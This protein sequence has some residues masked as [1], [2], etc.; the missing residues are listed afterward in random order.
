[1]HSRQ[2]PRALFG[3]LLLL[4]IPLSLAQAITEAARAKAMDAIE[5]KYRALV[6]RPLPERQKQTLAFMKT[7]PVVG[8]AKI[9]ED[10]NICL[11]FKD[12]VPYQ[13]VTNARYD[14]PP[15]KAQLLLLRPDLWAPFARDADPT[16]ER[17][18]YAAPESLLAP[19]TLQ[20][21]KPND[22][23]A[24]VKARMC[25]ALG[26]AFK[27]IC[28]DVR[29][30][31]TDNG[32][33]VV[34]GEDASVDTLMRIKDYGVFFMQCHGG[35][36]LIYD[37][38][39]L[40]NVEEYILT[41][42]DEW[43]D[44]KTGRFRAMRLFE[45]GYLGFCY[46]SADYA[47]ILRLSTT[48][49]RYYTITKKFIK[50]YW[51]FA[52][53]S[54]VFV[55]GCTTIRLKDVMATRE[56]NA[57]VFAG[58]DDLSTGKCAPGSLFLWD[59]LLGANEHG[60]DESGFPQRPFDWADIEKDMGR[61]RL[62]PQPFTY[63][64][65]THKPT[66]RFGTGQG[67]FGLLAPSIKFARTVPYEKKVELHG[68]FGKDP[69]QGE[70]KVEIDNIAMVIEKWEPELITI[71]LPGGEQGS[72]GEVKVT[73][74][75]RASNSRWLSEWKGTANVTIWGEDTLRFE[76]NFRLR[77]VADPWEV[78]EHAGDK[79]TSPF[80][81]GLHSTIGSACSWGASGEK[82]DN[83]GKVI[84]RW[85]GGATP[86]PS[87]DLGTNIAGS[88]GVGGTAD[89]YSK[90]AW[91]MFAI[92]DAMRYVS[93]GSDRIVPVKLADFGNGQPAVYMPFNA[94]FDISGGSALVEDEPSKVP[95]EG[96]NA[97]ATW[98]SM[99]CGLKMPN[100]A[101]R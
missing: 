91:V 32:Y 21:S 47:N 92:I 73:S 85:S 51:K 50:N 82:K 81:F 44:A 64:G 61:K 58:F 71:L 9:S 52:D 2:L 39:K 1:M 30:L 54:F 46:A 99:A 84:T 35:N 62:W 72:C 78:R 48:Q 24:N 10:G 34:P 29:K 23:P 31:L 56:V 90:K 60:P 101:R 83:E 14:E 53:N 6:E 19:Y 26:N 55:S 16:P 22:L 70:R 4:S 57:S 36:G 63:E 79:A 8:E 67:N 69:G 98:S 5:A 45:E 40:A 7:L 33:V 3:L 74:R 94:D 13:I 18:S 12:R 80:A 93:H 49:K 37:P 76:A 89:N 87:V 43:S 20:Q 38:V 86:K 27:N 75:G 11:L 66:L 41:S 77:F 68:I 97:K 17:T 88:F 95:Y 25:F 28:G 15:P 65:N 59:R 42:G 96:Q 100:N